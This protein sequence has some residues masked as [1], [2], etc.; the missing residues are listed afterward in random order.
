MKKAKN[1]SAWFRQSGAR[2]I[3][4]PRFIEPHFDSHTKSIGSLLL[5][6][7]DLHEHLSTLFVIALGSTH[8]KR[9]LAIWHATRSDYSKRK[10]LRSVLANSPDPGPRVAHPDGSITGARPKLIEEITWILDAANKLEDWRD[11]SAHTPLKYSYVGD[12]LSFSNILSAHNIF[13]F[14]KQIVVPQTGFANPRALKVE[15]NNRNLLVEYRYARDRI[16]ILRDY[17][18]AIEFAWS[19]PPVPWPDRPALPERKPSQRS[20]GPALRRKQKSP[21]RPLPPSAG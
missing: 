20:K 6:W 11:D 18:I 7:N 4:R 17:A 12:L 21:A 9:S 14:Q 16:L 13:D 3:P 1:L 19:A 2:G 10:L 5:A 15:Q 8:W